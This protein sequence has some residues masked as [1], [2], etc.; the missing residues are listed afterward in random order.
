MKKNALKKLSLRRAGRGRRELDAEHLLP[1]LLLPE[2]LHLLL[3]GVRLPIGRVLKSGR[4][5][6]RAGTARTRGCRG[7]GPP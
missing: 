6:F 2:R 1:D 5:F 3:V 7:T 4:G